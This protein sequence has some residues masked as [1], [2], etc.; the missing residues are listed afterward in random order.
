MVPVARSRSG[1]QKSS[2]GQK[3]IEIK[4]TWCQ[5]QLEVTSKG[6]G[7]AIPSVVEQMGCQLGMRQLEGKW[8]RCKVDAP[9][10][11]CLTTGD[12]AESKM[13]Q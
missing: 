13:M 11:L 8:K 2:Y 3:R 4:E 10:L 1:F 6:G 9:Q 12:T 7:V 5:F